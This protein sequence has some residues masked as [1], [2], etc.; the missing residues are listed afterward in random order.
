MKIIDDFQ[1][2]RILRPVE[3]PRIGT[4]EAT[5]LNF[6]A[7]PGGETLST[8]AF[9]AGVDEISRRGGGRLSVPSGS[10]VTGTVERKSGVE[11]HLE[12]GAR[13]IGSTERGDYRRNGRWFALLSA[14]DQEDISI[15]GRGVI[16]G[17]GEELAL[18]IDRQYH[19]GDFEG[20]HFQYNHRRHRPQE[21]ERPQIIE[22]QGCRRVRISGITLRNAACWV[23]TYLLCSDLTLDRLRG[24]SDVFWNNDGIDIENCR[25]VVVSRCDINA[26]DDG[27]CLKSPAGGRN[28][29]ILIEESRIRS[30]SNAVKFGTDSQG[31][32][33]GVLVRN[34]TVFDTYRSAA[35]LESVDGGILENVE[36]RDI[37]VWNTGNAFFIRLGNRLGK[38]K[39]AVRGSCR[40]IVIRNIKARTAFGRSDGAY[41]QRGPGYSFFHNPIPASITGVPGIC[42]ENVRLENIE[43]HYPGR[44]ARGMAYVPTDRLSAV[45]E[46]EEEYPEYTMFEELPAWG[47]YCRHVRGLGMNRIT[48]RLAQG[49]FRPAFVLDDVRGVFLNDLDL[50]RG[51][52]TRDLVLRD[53]TEIRVDDSL[54]DE[55]ERGS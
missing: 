26:A 3:A 32:F 15:S 31:G 22:M 24:D 4:A 11:L 17:R 49:D 28:E 55:I 43:I 20:Q 6:G 5:V 33:R 8:E 50:P 45:P 25:D 21:S 53:T 9:Q 19:R 18:N 14:K 27:I 44:A 48:L 12:E 35:A 51:R 47:L 29:R 38:R 34:L 37:T 1:W 52:S 36:I 39:G 16:D 30:S 13:I 2:E 41:N 42:V 23:Q 10:Y 40:N 7:V 54:K 46:M